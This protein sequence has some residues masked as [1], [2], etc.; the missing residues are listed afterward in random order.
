MA[1]EWFVRGGGK[2]YGP[3]DPAKLK[4]L[5]ADGKIGPQTEV[6]KAATGPWH[7][8]SKVGGLFPDAA[9]SASTP[10]SAE[11]A[12]S[13]PARRWYRRWWAVLVLYPFLAFMGCGIV[14]QL[15]VPKETLDRWK[16][17][18]EENSHK[19]AEQRSKDSKD[20]KDVHPGFTAGFMTGAIA[21]RN[22]ATKPSSAQLNAIAR[23]AATEANVAEKDRSYW[24]YQFELAF[25][26]GW[27]KGQ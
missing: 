3:L 12:S 10:L 6:A 20:S 22:G 26:M 15:V 4:Q 25:P 19:R 5:A 7:P 1:S 16:A 14:I 11:A 24:I 27:K 21:A 17:E 8:A 13:P 9:P 2:V 23:R 18:A